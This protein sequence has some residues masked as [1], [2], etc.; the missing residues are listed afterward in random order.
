MTDQLNTRELVARAIW[1]GVQDVDYDKV[2]PATQYQYRQTYA[3]ADRILAALPQQGDVAGLAEHIWNWLH[4]AKGRP[5]WVDIKDTPRG[6]KYLDVAKA[7]L[8]WGTAR[9]ALASTEGWRPE[10][11]AFADLMETK[12]RKNDHKPGW[13]G[14]NPFDLVRRLK[15]ETHELERVITEAFAETHWQNPDYK[16]GE[17]NPRG[18]RF[19]L[20]RATE[21]ERAELVPEIHP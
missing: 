12:L 13:K 7:A 6:H 21:E 17:W 14:D 20:R 18:S 10:V 8:D 3:T 4:P 1:S 15:E 16:E 2:G 5:D 11:R 19:V 9:T